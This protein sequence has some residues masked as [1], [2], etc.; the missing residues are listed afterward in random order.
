M[1]SSGR[2]L[3]RPFLSVGASTEGA[4]KQTVDSIPTRLFPFR[5]VLVVRAALQQASAASTAGER[6]K[7][8]K[9]D[10]GAA[11]SQCAMHGDARR[12]RY[13]G[14]Y[15]TVPTV[16]ARRKIASERGSSKTFSAS[17]PCVA[18]LAPEPDTGDG[19]RHTSPGRGPKGE[20]EWVTEE[21][22]GPGTAGGSPPNIAAARWPT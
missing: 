5:L 17:V 19:P 10:M 4:V 15:C 20:A 8:G 18:R 9:D 13:L 2:T 14:R 3:S 6:R 1:M 21:G 22:E 11:E 16:Y 7:R 12:G